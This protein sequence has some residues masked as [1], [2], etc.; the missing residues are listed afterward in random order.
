MFHLM[1]AFKLFKIV[2]LLSL[3]TAPLSSLSSGVCT[4]EQYLNKLEE[5]YQT[6]K[7]NSE[8]NSDFKNEFF[9][10]YSLLSKG[11]RDLSVSELEELNKVHGYFENYTLSSNQV[12]CFNALRCREQYFDGFL[13]LVRRV[14]TDDAREITENY[15]N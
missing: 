15:F 11:D 12:D 4:P 10:K 13:E 5:I 2:L 7:N 1:R 14:D 9:T 3:A 8:L 6:F